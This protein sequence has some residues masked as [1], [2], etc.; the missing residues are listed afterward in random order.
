MMPVLPVVL[1]RWMTED[2]AGCLA[3]HVA[4]R[5]SGETLQTSAG[6]SRDVLHGG[7]RVL[8]GLIV[9]TR[10]K[11]TRLVTQLTLLLVPETLQNA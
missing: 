9:P 4:R 8:E 1:L 6:Q 5:G 7:P 3:S 11:E 2:G 10:A